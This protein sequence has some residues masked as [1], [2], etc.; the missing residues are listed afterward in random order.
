[1][2]N[3]ITNGISNRFFFAYLI[4]QQSMYELERLAVER[5]MSDIYHLTDY[6]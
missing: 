3:W 6:V 4:A 2:Q 5:V 1:M